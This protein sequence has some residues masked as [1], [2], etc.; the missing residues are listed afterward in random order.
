MNASSSAKIDLR[1]QLYFIGINFNGRKTA[2]DE[3]ENVT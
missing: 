3:K 1:L 2:N